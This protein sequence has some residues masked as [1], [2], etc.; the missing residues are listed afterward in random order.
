MVRK[1]QVRPIHQEIQNRVQLDVGNAFE[2]PI[3]F[4][5]GLSALFDALFV[6][7]LNI[8]RHDKHVAAPTVVD[9]FKIAL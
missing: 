1:E 5:V 6:E 9:V 4:R 8:G 3:G 2:I 7:F